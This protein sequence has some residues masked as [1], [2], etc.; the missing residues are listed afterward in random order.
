MN[1]IN[2]LLDK[3]YVLAYFKKKLLPL[4]KNYS[5][6]NLIEIIPHKKYIWSNTYHVVF[7][8][9][10]KLSNNHNSITLPIFISAH[11]SESRKHVYQSLNFL[12]SKN[13]SEETLTIPKPLFY[14][15]KFNGCFYV[16][17]EGTNLYQ[18]IRSKDITSIKATIPKV[19]KWFSKLHNT[20][21]PTNEF[22]LKESKISNVV[23]G[24]ANI[25]KTIDNNYPNYL[26]DYNSIYNVLIK[27]EEE[28]LLKLKKL[29]VVHGDAHPEN[30]IQIDGKKLGVIDFTDLCLAD[31]ARDIGTFIQQL[32]Y[33]CDRKL[34]DTKLSKELSNDFLEHY[35]KYAKIIKDDFLLDRINNYYNWTCIRTATYFL[36]HGKLITEKQFH[37]KAIALINDTKLRMKL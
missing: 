24:K 28:Y 18:L 4:Y 22:K 30:I 9:N 36:T 11:S 35:L 33:M 10:V 12:W 25:L 16:G 13:F 20:K 17:I 27:N 5:S 7:Q 34:N 2:L 37:N 14:S 1:T 29:Y 21:K 32:E 8:F 3:K 31:Y 19:A 6:I 23:P 26:N 15:N